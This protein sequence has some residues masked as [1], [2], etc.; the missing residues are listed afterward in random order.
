MAS[1]GPGS[2]DGQTHLTLLRHLCED[3]LLTQHARKAR[4][5]SL[6]TG[7]PTMVCSHLLSL[8]LLSPSLLLLVWVN[9]ASA[10]PAPPA[11][12]QVINANEEEREKLHKE[13]REREKKLKET[14]KC[15][16]WVF[17]PGTAPPPPPFLLC[18]GASRDLFS[19][20]NPP[21]CGCAGVSVVTARR[22]HTSAL[23]REKEL[24]EELERARKA[25][26]SA[27]EAEEAAPAD[28]EGGA[29]GATPPQPARRMTAAE[30][31]AAI[32]AAEEKVGP[33]P[34]MLSSLGRA[35]LL[36]RLRLTS[37]PGAA[38]P[39]SQLKEQHNLIKQIERECRFRPSDTMWED[40]REEIA[41]DIEKKLKTVSPGDT[42]QKGVFNL[43]GR[44][45]TR[46]GE[47]PPFSLLASRN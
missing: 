46:R 32:R 10:S 5:P 39:A 8:L 19:S 41:A 47:A 29:E 23:Q 31:Q 7:V 15:A 35:T 33:A 25:L 22:A 28:D 38:F 40:E 17:V 6:L 44:A 16:L 27:G 2:V 36:R 20:L 30:A 13:L 26:S 1:S 24:K 42:R 45:L 14:E 43:H 3:V 34:P 11:R 21:P 4:H 37:R 12:L 18:G 9:P